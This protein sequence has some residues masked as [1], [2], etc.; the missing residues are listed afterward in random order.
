MFHF[1]VGSLKKIKSESFLVNPHFGVQVTYAGNQKEGEFFL[2]PY[3]DEQKKSVFYFAFD[4]FEQKESFE[5]MLKIS[6]VGPK[7]AF[8][9]VQIPIDELARAIEQLDTKLFQTIPG[10][11]PKLAKKIILELKG[12]FQLQEAFDIGQNQKL[13]KS[14]VK[15]LQN[16]GYE[17]VRIKEVLKMYPHKLEKDQLAEVIKRV[18]K[19]I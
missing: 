18:I 13:F 7:T 4:S 6:G 15:S 2:Y 1:F 16:L 5:K 17:P 9:I 19:E 12:N 11:G 14:V 3:L 8:Q 10:I